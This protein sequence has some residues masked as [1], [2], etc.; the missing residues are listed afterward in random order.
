MNR[1]KARFD[2]V[3][4][5]VTVHCPHCDSP[6]A[7]PLNGG[8]FT[9]NAAAIQETSG[10]E[11][12]CRNCSRWFRLPFALRQLL[13][14]S[15]EPVSHDLR[16]SRSQVE[17]ICGNCAGDGVEPIYT[18]LTTD[19]RCSKCGGRNYEVVTKPDYKTPTGKE[20]SE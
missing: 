5:E 3:G 8:G 15:T 9:W 19:H 6:V 10:R 2:V 4:I 12:Q 17:I 11:T 1:K 14:P 13:K 7:T 20:L 16:V 18:L